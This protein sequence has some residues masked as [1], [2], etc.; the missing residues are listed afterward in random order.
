MATRGKSDTLP[1]ATGT[2]WVLRIGGPPAGT[3]CG[4]SPPGGGYYALSGNS[5][6]TVTEFCPPSQDEFV[7]SMDSKT[8]RPMDN[9][10]IR[11]AFEDAMVASNPD[12]IPGTGKRKETGGIIW[13]MPDGSLRATL[14]NDP[15]ATECRVKPFT[16]MDS[17]K[18]DPQAIA[19]ASY[20]THPQYDGEDIYGCAPTPT[21]QQLAQTLGDNRFVPWATPNDPNAGGGSGGDWGSTGSEHPA[22]V[23][24]K[25]NY[26]YRLD[27]N[28]PVADRKKNKNKFVLRNLQGC[29]AMLPS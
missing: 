2:L 20:H 7:S 16:Q 25:D 8:Y 21:G 10:A 23:I 5:S 29:A 14:V 3:N 13:R 6:I 11:Q 15:N 1:L 19:I 12:S 24:T 26:V 22:Y 9:P 17:V 28:V 4:S 27:P 18:P